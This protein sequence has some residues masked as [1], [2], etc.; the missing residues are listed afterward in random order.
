M[1]EAIAGTGAR[2]VVGTLDP[3][4]EVVRAQ[5]VAL[6]LAARAG[7]DADRPHHLSRS[8]VLG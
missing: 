8:V 3:M 2:L 1:A 6:E 7:R 5:R 4:A